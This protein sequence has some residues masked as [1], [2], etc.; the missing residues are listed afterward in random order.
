MALNQ[1]A[2]AA[3][4]PRNTRSAAA[5]AG[6]SEP[7]V[8]PPSAM[9]TAP[10]APSSA[11]A[12]TGPALP[13][14]AHAV[15]EDILRAM[16]HAAANNF[17]TKPTSFQGRAGTASPASSRQSDSSVALTVLHDE[18]MAAEKR[19]RKAEKEMLE[20]KFNAV[21]AEKDKASAIQLKMI[22]DLQ[23]KLEAATTAYSLEKSKAEKFEGMYELQRNDHQRM[24]QAMLGKI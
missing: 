12:S 13:T 11:A 9:P 10:P 21:V 7:Q 8:V 3:V 1:A 24:F 6:P 18:K 4:R 2:P 22:E 14:H 16:A 17:G 19:E 5:K 20:D 23:R 15:P